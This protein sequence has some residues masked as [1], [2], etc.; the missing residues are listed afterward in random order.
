MMRLRFRPPVLLKHDGEVQPPDSP[1][2]PGK[3]RRSA[4]RGRVWIALLD[5]E[6]FM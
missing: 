2:W 4:W 1:C 5:D 3:F 6:C